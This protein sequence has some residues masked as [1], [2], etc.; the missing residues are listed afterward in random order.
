LIAL[1]DRF[2]SYEPYAFML[3]RNDPAFRLAVDRALAAMY[4]SGEILTI[5]DRWFGI[6]GKPSE[7]IK[8]MYLVTGLPE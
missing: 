1:S 8:A 4:R 3:H 2:F 5:Y 7:A 6:L